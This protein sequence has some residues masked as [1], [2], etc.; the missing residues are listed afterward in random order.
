MG[1]DLNLQ[2]FGGRGA[3]YEYAR[4][5]IGQYSLSDITDSKDK[6]VDFF[7]AMDRIKGVTLD[8]EENKIRVSKDANRQA[9]EL[10]DELVDRMVD[11]NPQMEQ[12]YKDLRRLLSGTYTIS[13]KDRSNIPDFGR[14]VRSSDNFLKIGRRGMSLDSKYQELAELYP[15]YFNAYEVTNPA[16]QLQDINRVLGQLKSYSSSNLNLSAD[17]R[18]EAVRELKNDI[19]KSYAT[20]MNRRRYA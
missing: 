11:R 15:G 18:R 16:E 12:D 9:T 3:R 2:Y 7:S 10:A 6:I 13:D 20:I 14:Y 4:D 1:F 17:E 19:I 8:F 5:L